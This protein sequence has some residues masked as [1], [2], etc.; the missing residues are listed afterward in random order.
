MTEAAGKE[1]KCNYI[2]KQQQVAMFDQITSAPIRS[3]MESATITM[4]LT[5][6][7][8]FAAQNVLRD[9][10]MTVV[11]RP[12]TTMKEWAENYFNSIK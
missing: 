3:Y 7:E 2:D 4:E 5:R 6:T 8:K 10:V 1:I 11:G 9:D 12:G